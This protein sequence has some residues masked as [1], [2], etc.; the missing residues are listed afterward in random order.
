MGTVE[1]SSSRCFFWHL[2]KSDQTYSFQ[3]INCK[4]NSRGGGAGAG[5]GAGTG[6]AGAWA[7]IIR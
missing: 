2:G 7:G 3:D 4:E 6:G 1:S 5:A